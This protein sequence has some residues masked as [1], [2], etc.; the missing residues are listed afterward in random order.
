MVKPVYKPRM[1]KAWRI[2]QNWAGQTCAVLA[3]GESMGPEVAEAVRQA[4]AVRVIVTNN[5]FRLARWADILFA[6]D[7]PW[8]DKYH[9]ETAGFLGLKVC[10]DGSG[11]KYD[12]VLQ[13]QNSG[14]EGF[15]PDPSRIRCGGC[16]GYAAVHIAAHLGCARILLC[17]FDMK[18]GHWHEPHK[19]PLREHGD[20]IYERWIARFGTLAPELA[21]RGIEVLN[22]TPGSALRCFPAADLHQ[23]LGQRLAA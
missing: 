17:G 20:G 2:E 14:L 9:A 8:W 18:G 3:S 21:A 22:C 10:A 13:I 7:A 5:T 4:A 12:D 23:V 11:T 1:N 15:D 19:Y 6:A 16:S